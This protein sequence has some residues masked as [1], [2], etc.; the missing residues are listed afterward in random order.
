MPYVFQIER[1][2]VGLTPVPILSGFVAPSGVSV[3]IKNIGGNSVYLGNSDVSTSNGFL[4][5][6]GQSLTQD[7]T[8]YE[9]ADLYGLSVNAGTTVAYFV[10]ITV[11]E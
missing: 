10:G 4:L 6:T 2:V 7:L 11:K 8:S 1:V 9:G 3:T 5:S